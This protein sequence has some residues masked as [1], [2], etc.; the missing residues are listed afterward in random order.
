MSKAEAGR[1]AGDV[2]ACEPQKVLLIY[3][4][5]HGRRTG[6]PHKFAFSLE[7]TRTYCSLLL[8]LMSGSRR[9]PPLPAGEENGGGRRQEQIVGGESSRR[10]AGEPSSSRPRSA[11]LI[12]PEHFV[13]AVAGRIAEDAALV[14]RR[15]DAAPAVVTFFQSRVLKNFDALQVCSAWRAISFSEV[16]WQDLTRRV[17]SPRHRR[18]LPSWREEFISLHRTAANFRAGRCLHNHI[19]PPISPALFCRRLAFSDRYLATGFSDG[20]VRLY[21]L[22]VAALLA[23]Y[24]LHLHRDRLGHFSTSISGI[25]LLRNQLVFASQDGDIGVAAIADDNNFVNA[26]AR[27]ARAG[28]PVENGTLVDFVGDGRW[29]VGLF[30][31]APGWSWRVWDGETEQQVYAGG[32]LTDRDSVAGWHM[33]ADISGPSVARV[34]V[35]ESGVVIGCTSSRV[36]TVSVEGEVE[37]IAEMELRRAAAADALGASDGRVVVVDGGFRGWS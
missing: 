36:Q 6:G 7:L 30:A 32:S 11:D 27:R 31:G 21:N 18:R 37:V 13:E 17:W 16:L 33:L 14:G 10:R 19:H 15:L 5:N 1:R 2:C 23:V 25:I 12:W 28:N 26:V 8:G 4:H 3:T 24:D 9:R 29:W 35:A 20:S 34:G 22:P